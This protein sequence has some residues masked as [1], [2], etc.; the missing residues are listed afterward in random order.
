MKR[1]LTYR[2]KNALT[3]H[4]M[5]YSKNYHRLAERIDEYTPSEW[6]TGE[7]RAFGWRQED[8]HCRS[9]RIVKE[10]RAES[11]WGCGRFLGPSY[12]TNPRLL[13]LIASNLRV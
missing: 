1:C 8:V 11:R 2:R 6:R 9:T 10:A 13:C 7:P 5:G 4:K 3:K 12:S